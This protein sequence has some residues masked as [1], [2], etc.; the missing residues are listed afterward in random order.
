MIIVSV[1]KRNEYKNKSVIILSFVVQMS[2]R[3]R[4]INHFL[5]GID[6]ITDILMAMLYG[7]LNLRELSWEN[8]A[9]KRY[10]A[11]TVD[12]A[13]YRDNRRRLRRLLAL[14]EAALIEWYKSEEEDEERKSEEEEE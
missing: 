6:D 5:G 1:D 4:E 11:N 7:G 8:K 13:S 9:P 12:Y 14:E 10:R 3:I 2:A